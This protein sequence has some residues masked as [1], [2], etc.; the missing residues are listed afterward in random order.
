MNPV[1][2]P[3]VTRLQVTQ[4]LGLQLLAVPAS[5]LLLSE[6]AVPS[7]GSCNSPCFL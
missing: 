6:H 2:L 7:S 3:M 4:E 5:A 1:A